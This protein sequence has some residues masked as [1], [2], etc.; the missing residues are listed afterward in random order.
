MRQTAKIVIWANK[1]Q[2]IAANKIDSI[3]EDSLNKKILEIKN[4]FKDIPIYKVSA[5][6]NVGLKE[7]VLKL[8]ECVNEVKNDTQTFESEVDLDTLLH[9]DI[10]EVIINKTNNDTYEITGEKIKKM[11]GYTN[12]DTEKG[13]NFLQQFLK[14]RKRCRAVYSFSLISYFYKYYL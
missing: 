3:D 11:L 4:E 12:L 14:K 10:E 5:L 2:I 1:K 9:V 6:T 8:A 13:L 7:L